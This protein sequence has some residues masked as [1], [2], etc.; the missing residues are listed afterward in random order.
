V[1]TGPHPLAERVVGWFLPPACREHVLGDLYERNATTG[2][3]LWDAVRTVPFAVWGQVRRT[4]LSGHAYPEAITL[5]TSVQSGGSG[6]RVPHS[7]GSF[8]RRSL[9]WLL[10][11]VPLGAVFGLGASFFSPP[12]Y[13]AAASVLLLGVP[14]EVPQSLMLSDLRPRLGQRLLVVSIQVLSSARL[15]RIIQDLNLYERERRTTEDAIVRMRQ[16]I[17][18]NIVASGESGA[19]FT[20]AYQAADPKIAMRVAERLASLFEQENL[21]DAERLFSQTG[22]SIGDQFRILD[23][24]RLPARPIEPVRTLWSGLGAAA[25]LI[26]ACLILVVQWWPR[27]PQV[28]PARAVPA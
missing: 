28:G 1:E 12:V 15:E 21:E 17:S 14:S 5:A 11:L 24:A 19:W 6:M 13:R 25:G 10:A 23:P 7:D 27:P 4:T 20:V 22:N 26:V 18:L 8:N 16:D 2:R 3:Y 9:V